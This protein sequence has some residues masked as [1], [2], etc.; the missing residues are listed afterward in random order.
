MRESKRIERRGGGGGLRRGE[1][2][3]SEG[4]VRVRGRWC[5]GRRGCEGRE[6]RGGSVRGCEG[7]GREMLYCAVHSYLS[8]PRGQT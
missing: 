5:K 1:G 8:A 3:V 6:G 4:R 7:R 2:T